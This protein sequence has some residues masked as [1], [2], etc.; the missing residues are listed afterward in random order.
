MLLETRVTVSTVLPSFGRSKEEPSFLS[1]SCHLCIGSPGTGAF[2]W[3]EMEGSSCNQAKCTS[4]KL[5]VL[6]PLETVFQSQTSAR[7]SGMSS[8][9]P[10]SPVGSSFASFAVVLVGNITETD[11]AIFR[12]VAMI[13][14]FEDITESLTFG[15]HSRSAAAMILKPA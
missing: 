2:F 4:S 13:G 5:C 1:S 15:A 3:S 7:T 10:T 8:N 11:S 6:V 9:L 12:H 14:L